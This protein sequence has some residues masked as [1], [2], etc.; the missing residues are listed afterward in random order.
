MSEELSRNI[1]LAEELSKQNVKLSKENSDVRR[2]I[3][4]LK[5]EQV[6]NM[7]T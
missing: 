5:D 3:K 2:D 6:D 4:K 7:N 1:R